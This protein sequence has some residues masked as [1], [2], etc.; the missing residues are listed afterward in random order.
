VSLTVLGLEDDDELVTGGTGHPATPT[1]CRCPLR[2]RK[3]APGDTGDTYS[4]TKSST[5]RMCGASSGC[6]ASFRANL[7]SP[8]MTCVSRRTASAR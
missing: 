8:V 7:S 4:E 6:A 2:I 3:A 5:D 1:S